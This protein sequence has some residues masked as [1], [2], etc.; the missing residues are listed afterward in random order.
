MLLPS[1]SFKGAGSILLAVTAW[2]CP[3]TDGSGASAVS[4]VVVLALLT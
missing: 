4:A 2:L 1:G 3:M